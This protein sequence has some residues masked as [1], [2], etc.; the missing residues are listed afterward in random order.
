MNANISLRRLLLGLVVLFG[1]LVAGGQFTFI[2]HT[3]TAELL[4]Q[5]RQMTDHAGRFLAANLEIDLSADELEHHAHHLVAQMVSLP[6]LVYAAYVDADGVVRHATTPALAGRRLGDADLPSA[7]LIDAARRQRGSRVTEDAAHKRLW[8]VFPV[9]LPG[10]G[11]ETS[12]ARSGLVVLLV[13]TA[14]IQREALPRALEQT[15]FV[16]VPILLLSLGIGVLVKMLLTDRIEQLL[17]YTRSQVEG[18]SLPPP[19]TGRDELGQLGER[20]AALMR[21]VVASRDFHVHL[22]DGMPN[23]IWRAG[24]DGKCDYFN[25]AWLQFTGR[26]LEQELGDGWA[27]GVHP[28][29]AEYCLGGYRAAVAARTP[30]YL[31]YRLRHHDGSYHW[32]ADHGQPIFGPGGE[33]IGY[34]GS[35][36]DL[37]QQKEAAAAIR[38]SEVRFRGLVERSLVGVYLIQD[39]VMSYANPRLAEWFGYPSDEIAGVPVDDL[40][41][42]EDVLLVREMLRQRLEAGVL[43]LNYGFRARRRDGSV[44]PVEVFGTR[45]DIDGRL[46]VIGTLLDVTERERD[47]AALAAAAEVVEASPTV[48]FRWSPDEG[49]PVRYVSE[50]VHRWGYR[51]T[52]MLKGDFRFADVV[53]PDDIDR[54]GAEVSAHLA[55]GR[56]EFVQEYRLR[57]ADGSYIWIEDFISAHRDEDGALLHL[58][59]L[60]TDISARHAAQEALRQF[61]AELEERVEQRTRELGVVNKELETFAYSVSHDLKAPLR[62]IDGYSHLLLEEHAAQLDEE[63]RLFLGNIRAGV[64]QMSRLIDDL[65]AY[66]RLERRNLQHTDINLREMVHGILA[67]RAAELERGGARVEIE[68]PEDI[69]VRADV[70]GLAQVLRN[71]VDNAFKYSRN[72]APPLVRIGASTAGDVHH[73]WVRDNG[74]GFDMQFHDRIFEIFQR[75]QRAEEYGGTGVG[76]AMVKRAVTRMGGRVWAE[77]APGAGATFHVELPR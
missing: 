3:Y 72:A 2:M 64:R 10:A 38:A 34:L 28:Q 41:A 47:R 4:H 32:L 58:E 66:S 7:A 33:F 24:V 36:F 19:V 6:H 52:D 46:A 42:S 20:L 48:L 51:A 59:G 68:V 53:H 63:G 57:R 69:V 65:L 37:Q 31:E 22:L 71:L 8:A 21:S 9:R 11:G 76:L 14:M 55:A 18:R 44:F 29:D 75:L 73:L 26:R 54:V 67:E 43:H 74:I 49:W 23:P 5:T 60:L 15:L 39:G 70:D 27:E 35:C 25:R 1:L 56:R 13:D 16:L 61:N 40:V 45:I 50:N 12:A 62:G 77:S 17:A 30:F